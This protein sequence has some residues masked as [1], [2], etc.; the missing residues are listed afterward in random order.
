MTKNIDILGIDTRN[1][2]TNRNW[3]AE[4]SLSISPRSDKSVVDK[5]R[6][7]GPL[8]IQ[9]PFYPEGD[10]CHLYLLHPPA[11]IVGG[12]HLN[13][14]LTIQKNGAALVTTPGA[15]KFYRSSGA[16]AKQSQQFK[17]DNNASLEWLPQETIYFPNANANLETTIHMAEKANFIGWEI[18]CLGLPV[19]KKDFESGKARIGFSL[20]R[21]NKPILLEAMLVSEE[22]KGFQAAFL[23][24]QPVFATFIA[25]GADQSLLD[26]IREE[27]PAGKHGMWGATLIDDILIIRYLGASTNEARSI[28]ISAWQQTRPITLNRPAVLPRIWAT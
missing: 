16:V 23:Q 3:K 4:L 13:L 20:Y 27:I 1:N 19:N 15:T 12:D 7:N 25:T 28:F 24:D 14:E 5:S 22:K 17:I 9:N 26:T 8:T 10:I 6:Q 21:K 2:K 11:G 18:H